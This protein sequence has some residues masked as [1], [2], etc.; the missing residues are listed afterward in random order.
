MNKCTFLKK[1]MHFFVHSHDIL[2][3]G[4]TKTNTTNSWVTPRQLPGPRKRSVWSGHRVARC[5][6]LSSPPNAA[7]EH[8]GNPCSVGCKTWRTFGRK[9]RNFLSHMLHVWYINLD[10]G[11]F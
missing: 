3:Y 7:F 8:L 11:D 6:C 10:L 1:N 2:M 4:L 5:D 9:I